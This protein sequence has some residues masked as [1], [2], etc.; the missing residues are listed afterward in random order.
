MGYTVS[1]ECQQL[2]TIDDFDLIWSQPHQI[3]TCQASRVEC[4]LLRRCEPTLI[5]GAVW[6]LI[7]RA[8]FEVECLREKV[9][10]VNTV[11]LVGSPH[12]SYN[13]TT[14]CMIFFNRNIDLQE[15]MHILEHS[16]RQD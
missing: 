12:N 6:D 4:S 9:V 16:R 15:I 3:L 13:S 11:S 1:Q 7:V 14:Y 10:L 2:V 8:T 5:G